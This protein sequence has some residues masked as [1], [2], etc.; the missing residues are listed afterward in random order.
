MKYKLKNFLENLAEFRGLQ[1]K[2][3]STANPKRIRG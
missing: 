3:Y 2:W 1:P